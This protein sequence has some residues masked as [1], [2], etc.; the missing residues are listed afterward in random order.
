MVQ[1]TAQNLRNDADKAEEAASKATREYESVRQEYYR[2]RRAA[3]VSRVAAE[4]AKKKAEENSSEDSSQ[5]NSTDQPSN[6]IAVRKEIRSLS[7][8]EQARFLA[9]WNEMMASKGTKAG[10]SDFFRLAGYHGWPSK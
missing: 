6:G 1:A 4:K 10:S 3:D 2:A 8:S 7:E 5:S 9:A